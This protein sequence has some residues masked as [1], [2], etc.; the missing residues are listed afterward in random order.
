MGSYCILNRWRIT[1]YWPIFV[2][3]FGVGSLK[4]FPFVLQGEIV[5]QFPMGKRFFKF[6][7]KSKWHE[8]K[9]V[10]W[11]PFRNGTNILYFLCEL[12]N[13]GS[14]WKVITI[15]KHGTASEKSCDLLNNKTVFTRLPPHVPCKC[16]KLSKSELH[17]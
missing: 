12:M 16:E 5:V 2:L 7:P 8:L 4:L 13:H 10:I 14:L 3:F 17:S 9:S 11:P 1:L 6:P 15:Y